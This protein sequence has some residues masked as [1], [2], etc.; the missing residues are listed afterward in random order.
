MT[1]QADHFAWR[2]GQIDI[3]ENG[4]RA[5][6]ETHGAQFNRAADL[7]EVQRMRR[8]GNARRMVED[9]ENAFG[10]GRRLLGH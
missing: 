5:V 6:T 9:V 8:L 3:L 1:H 7:L 4:A 2:D 10:A